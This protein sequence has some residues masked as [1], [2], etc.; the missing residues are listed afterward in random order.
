MKKQEIIDI[1]KESFEESVIFEERLF[2]KGIQYAEYL[3]DEGAVKSILFLLPC[4]IITKGT[5]IPAKYIFAAATKS[6]SRKKGYM[7]KLLEKIKIENNEFLFLRPANENLQ[8]YYTKIGFKSIV[9]TSSNCSIK[10]APSN[11]MRYLS[12][13][14]TE[15]PGKEFV[16]MY[17]SKNNIEIDKINFIYSME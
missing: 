13:G 5:E 9:G 7:E 12:D 15:E 1:Y 3:E 16:L 10:I 4:T 2:D 11:I 6:D 8:K 17:Y 14:I